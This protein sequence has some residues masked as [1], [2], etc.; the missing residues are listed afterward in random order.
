MVKLCNKGCGTEISLSVKT[1]K[2]LPYDADCK[3]HQCPNKS[4]PPPP[5]K[6]QKTDSYYSGIRKVAELTLEE[7]NKQLEDKRW[8]ILKVSEKQSVSMQPAAAG[9]IPI[10]ATAI[11]YIVGMRE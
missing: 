3:I 11:I 9:V 10:T 4:P 8:E 2:W 6:T 1:G 7:A 5:P